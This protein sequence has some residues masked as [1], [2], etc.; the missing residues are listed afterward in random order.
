MP[1]VRKARKDAFFD[2][3]TESGAKQV[4]LPFVVVF[5]KGLIMRPQKQFQLGMPRSRLIRS[6]LHCILCD[7]AGRDIP[8]P[9]VLHPGSFQRRARHMD[10]VMDLR[11]LQ[12]SPA[13]ATL[14]QQIRCAFQSFGL[15]LGGENPP[16][17]FGR[18]LVWIVQSAS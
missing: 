17:A 15:M 13:E 6:C 14:A 5:F 12:A 4:I 11:D 16:P 1:R 8:V 3:E 7:H 2:H 10:A 9:S 18:G